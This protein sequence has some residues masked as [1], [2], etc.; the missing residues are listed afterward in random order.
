MPNPRPRYKFNVKRLLIVLAVIVGLVVGFMTVM[1]GDEQETVAEA[2]PPA[3]PPCFSRCNTD[4]PVPFQFPLS[5]TQRN[6]FTAARVQS[7]E[8]LLS[9]TAY[10]RN[11]GVPIRFQVYI[12]A[13]AYTPGDPD[14]Y[15]VKDYTYVAAYFVPW[16]EAATAERIIANPQS[17]ESYDRIILGFPNSYLPP[18][19]QRFMEVWGYLYWVSTLTNPNSTS[20]RRPVVLVGQYDT[21]SAAE[22]ISPAIYRALPPF[23]ANRS[24]LTVTV[25]GVDFAIDQTRVKLTLV[26]DGAGKGNY[27]IENVGITAD[28]VPQAQIQAQGAA[29]DENSQ[30]NGADLETRRPRDVTVFFPG[31]PNPTTSAV[32]LTMPDPGGDLNDSMRIRLSPF[33]ANAEE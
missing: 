25:S 7:K 28:G 20:P 9:P 30:A 24:R 19:T 26:W 2:F 18:R 10:K 15:V 31:I 6:A 27:N 33:P 14:Y 12:P 1:G 11:R 17:L 22:I 29:V 4:N 23:A 8:A 21:M 13:D 3:S 32:D 16:N 5:D